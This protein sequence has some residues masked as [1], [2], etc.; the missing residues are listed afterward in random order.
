MSDDA[1]AIP[2]PTITP[3]AIPAHCSSK[4][5]VGHAK[6]IGSLTFAS[7]ML[8]LV[9]EI[10]A[11]HFL[12]AGNVVAT[13]FDVAFAIPN[14]FRKLFGEGALSAAFIPLYAQSV[15]TE[16]LE[17]ANRFAAASVNLLCAILI[18]ITLLG[19]IVLATMLFVGDPQRVDR[20]LM[21]KF[22][23]IM[24][25]Y[26]LLIC[27]GAF[28][29]GILQVHRRFAAPAAA[30]ILLNVVH[31][32]VL[33]TGASILGLKATP[34]AQSAEQ[35]LA[36]QTRLAYWLSLFVLV[37]GALQVMVLLPGLRAV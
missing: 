29:S 18:V 15:K 19:E 1:T 5:F 36:I 13:A 6:V 21:I 23:M 7:R 27:G 30:P 22:T 11:A 3:A 17:Q 25:P 28:L 14:L 34:L 10:V 16:S 2:P 24:L 20:L 37:A 33:F 12:G 32:A 35:V 4:A 9:R 8:G 26:V 31:I